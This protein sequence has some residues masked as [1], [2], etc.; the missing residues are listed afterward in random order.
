MSLL[1]SRDTELEMVKPVYDDKNE[2]VD[3]IFV[4]RTYRFEGFFR[5]EISLNESL[6]VDGLQLIGIESLINYFREIKTP[7]NVYG[8]LD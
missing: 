4:V 7:V 6:P 2:L 1:M 3:I 5:E 8:L